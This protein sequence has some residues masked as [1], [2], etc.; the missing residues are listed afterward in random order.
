MDVTIKEALDAATA[1]EQGLSSGS[2]I[3]SFI[4]D[5]LG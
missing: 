5:P 3:E 2:P 1:I 4:V